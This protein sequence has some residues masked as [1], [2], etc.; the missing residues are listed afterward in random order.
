MKKLNKIN[1]KNKMLK[2]FIEYI[3][4]I[5]TYSIIYY[6]IECIWKMSLSDWRML[7][8]GGIM[9]FLIGVQNNIFTYDIDFTYQIFVGSLMITLCEAIFGYQWNT[10]EGLK[11]WDYSNTVIYGVDGNVSLLFSLFAWTTLS[12]IVILLDDYIWY[13]IFK[14]G[15]KPYYIIF[16]KKFSFKK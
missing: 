4:L 5:L 6:L 15:D 9:G 12:G 3:I 11:I 16:G 10:I 1:I 7:V 13:Y 8:L 14:N 2:Y